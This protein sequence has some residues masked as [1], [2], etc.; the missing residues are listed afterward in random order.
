[1]VSKQ[2]GMDDGFK[3]END[4][5]GFNKPKESVDVI[6]DNK[7]NQLRKIDNRDIIKKVLASDVHNS[8]KTTD[9][10][11]VGFF[12]DKIYTNTEKMNETVREQAIASTQSFYQLQNTFDKRVKV[13]LQNVP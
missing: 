11:S 2:T 7:Q 10:K 8:L 4:E 5:K 6:E 1:M 9:N 12:E 13:N 3:I